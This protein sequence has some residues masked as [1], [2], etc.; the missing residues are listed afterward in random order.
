MSRTIFSILATISFGVL[1]IAYPPPELNNLASLTA[2]LSGTLLGFTFAGIS[3]LVALP[4]VP[5]IA[6][7]KKHGYYSLIL[8][9]LFW[10]AFC[11]LMSMTLSFITVWHPSAIIGA[12]AV[13]TFGGTLCQALYA[14][15]TFYQVIDTLHE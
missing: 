13:A 10:T 4:N 5:L 9:D 1:F 2:S 11:L 6:K 8:K 3:L 14:G 15:H 7:L 12:L